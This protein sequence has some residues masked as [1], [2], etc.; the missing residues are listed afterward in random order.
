ME[1]WGKKEGVTRYWTTLQKLTKSHL[2]GAVRIRR[3]WCLFGN[4][5]L[6]HSELERRGRVSP[7]THI[8]TKMP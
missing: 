4:V 1:D 7:G 5:G 3:F 6:G 2:E 8:K